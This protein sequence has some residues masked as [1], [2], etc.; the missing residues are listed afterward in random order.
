MILFALYQ[1]T[2]YFFKEA[3]ILQISRFNC[4]I[5]KPFG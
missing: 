4:T 2:F 3:Y 5:M 1:D